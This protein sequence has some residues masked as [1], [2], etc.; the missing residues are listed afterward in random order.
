MAGVDQLI[1]P[2]EVTALDL[3]VDDYG[4]LCYIETVRLTCA[5]CGETVERPQRVRWWTS[6]P[7]ARHCSPR[8]SKRSWERRHRQQH[9][10]V[11]P[12]LRRAVY[13]RDGWQC[14]FCGVRD[15][16]TVDHVLPQARGGENTL[17]NLQTLCGPCNNLKAD[18]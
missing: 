17:S 11:T 16:L 7:L 9:G 1:A 18:A 12:A 4:W 2:P 5:Y 10:R 6:P 8:C 15:D 13:D 14:Q 3:V